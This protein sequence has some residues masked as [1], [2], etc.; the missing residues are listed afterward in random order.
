MKTEIYIW[1]AIG[2]TPLT[3]RGGSFCD[4]LIHTTVDCE[5]PTEAKKVVKNLLMFTKH[6]ER[7]HFNM[8]AY[9]NQNEQSGWIAI[10]QMKDL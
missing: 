6:A 1:S 10:T 4:E 9:W 8:P 5:N 7:G 3:N 2:H